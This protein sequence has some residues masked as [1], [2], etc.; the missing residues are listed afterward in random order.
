MNDLKIK[1]LL[2]IISTSMNYMNKAL[3]GH[4]I[5]VTYKLVCILKDDPR[6]TY[7]EVCKIAWTVLYHDIGILEERSV[8]DLLE[9][10]FKK[11]N[12]GFSHAEYGCL[13]VKYF[14]SFPEYYQ[15][16]K[17]HHS[18]YSEFKDLDIDEKL[19]D[20][21]VILKAIDIIDLYSIYKKQLD[22]D[23]IKLDPYEVDI[24]KKLSCYFENEE[25]ISQKEI[26]NNLSN[27]LNNMILSPSQKYKML[28]ILVY[29]FDFKSR[30]TAVHCTTVV[31]ISS[32]LAKLF[33]VDE[34]TYIN[35][36]LGALLHDLGKIAIPYHIL[37]STGKL[38]KEDWKIMKSH[39]TITEEILKN[40]VDN[41]ILQIAIRHHETLDGMGYPYRINGSELTLPQ[42]IVAISDIVSALSQERSYKPSLS[43]DKMCAILNDMC[44][45]HKIC[46]VVLQ[47]FLK[48]KD[49]IYNRVLQVAY[50]TNLLYEKINE[51][52]N[53]AMADQTI[54]W[55]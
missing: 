46:P 18:T 10:E 33:E 42:R 13:F 54:F 1:N 11:K 7:Q 5:R 31:E 15:I 53:E 39:V 6:F 37:E 9:E 55:D 21:I 17:F 52:Y 49:K 26:E 45:N 41:A 2:S 40:N 8:K 4:C 19:K 29:S 12:I 44:H 30:H 48:N 50:E 28:K 38:N 25:D 27:F 36:C 16:I 23:K 22:I 34:S 47:M 51:E 35:I 24:V 14:S 32:L 3:T 43:L 20:V